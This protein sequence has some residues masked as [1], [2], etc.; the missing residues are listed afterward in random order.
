MERGGDEGAGGHHDE[1]GVREG[2]PD[3]LEAGDRD[4]QEGGHAEQ[5]ETKGPSVHGAPMARPSI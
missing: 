4:P 1:G 2:V 5:S 3:A